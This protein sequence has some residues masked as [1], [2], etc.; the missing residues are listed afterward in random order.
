MPGMHDQASC[1]AEALPNALLHGCEQFV[2]R[3]LAA[4]A[5][6]GAD[7][8]VLVV[9]GVPLALIS[10]GAA[11]CGAGLDGGADD[12]KIGL[13]LACQHAAGGVAQ[14]GA[15]KTQANAADHVSDVLLGQTRVGANGARVG[16]V[17]AIFNAA[18]KR[19][20]ID[21]G[22]AWMHPDDLSNTHVD[23]F[24]PSQSVTCFKTR[25]VPSGQYA[26]F[27]GSLGSRI[28]AEG[29]RLVSR[30]KWRVCSAPAWIV[31]SAGKTRGASAATSWRSHA[32][33][34]SSGR[35]PPP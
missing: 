14:I 26:R 19:L 8:T 10:T 16:A 11:R 23:P 22:W 33:P 9:M 13:R 27:D 17:D 3:L 21:V 4:P 2:A 18:K 6:C 31:R 34:G 1:P 28:R 32:P 35:A 24:L 15:V 25:G 29:V 20:A 5:G 30:A 7:A 12:A